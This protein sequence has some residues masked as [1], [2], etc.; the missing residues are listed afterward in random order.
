MLTQVTLGPTGTIVGIRYEPLKFVMRAMGI[1]RVDWENTFDAF[2]LM[3]R[4]ML[5]TLA[6][7]G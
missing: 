7:K 1:P 2:Q 4:H 6:R 5:R 3:E